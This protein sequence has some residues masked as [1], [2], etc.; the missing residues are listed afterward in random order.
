[1]ATNGNK[2]RY[3]LTHAVCAFETHPIMTCN[4]YYTFFVRCCLLATV[5]S[6]ITSLSG[7]EIWPILP[8]QMRVNGSV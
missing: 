4:A 7:R 2:Q 1:M 3:T 8:V 5:L 6:P